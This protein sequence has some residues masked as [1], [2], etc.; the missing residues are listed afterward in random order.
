MSYDLAHFLLGF[1]QNKGTTTCTYAHSGMMMSRGRVRAYTNEFVGNQWKNSMI[2]IS[3]PLETVTII[4]ERHSINNIKQTK[5]ARNPEF[6]RYSIRLV[7]FYIF[8][9]YDSE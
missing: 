2:P 6:S 7:D 4:D 9:Y 8:F 5:N 1:I 3:L